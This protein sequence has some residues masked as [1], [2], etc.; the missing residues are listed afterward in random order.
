[1]QTSGGS[2]PGRNGAEQQGHLDR[3]QATAVK[4]SRTDAIRIATWNVRTLFVAG[5]LENLNQEMDT[6]NLDILGVCE[7]RWTGNGRFV[8][9]NKEFFFSVGDAHARGVGLIM[10]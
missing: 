6:L 7:T 2:S 9:D 10:E 1:M 4:T 5:Q 8:S 3:H